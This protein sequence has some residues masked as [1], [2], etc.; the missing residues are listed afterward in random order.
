[1]ILTHDNDSSLE[2]TGQRNNIDSQQREAARRE[3]ME[4]R[5]REKELE[6][7]KV[8]VRL[9]PRFLAH[10]IKQVGLRFSPHITIPHIVHP[11]YSPPPI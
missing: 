1:M 3:R 9:P 11:P 6:G 10:P 4:E 5:E 7:I 8:Q 2:N